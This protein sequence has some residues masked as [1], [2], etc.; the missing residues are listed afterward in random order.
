MVMKQEFLGN[1]DWGNLDYLI[2]DLPPGTGD[3]IL[4]MATAGSDDVLTGTIAAIF[5]LGFPVNDAVQTGVFVHGY[6]GDL[7]TKDIGRDGLTAIERFPVKIN[8]R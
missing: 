6:A 5:G 2:A 4:T 3:E 1:V 8:I 7:A